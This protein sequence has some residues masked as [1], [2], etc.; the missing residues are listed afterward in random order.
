MVDGQINHKI[1]LNFI[2]WVANRKI[3]KV[4]LDGFIPNLSGWYILFY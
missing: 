4:R 1:D 3:R 2:N